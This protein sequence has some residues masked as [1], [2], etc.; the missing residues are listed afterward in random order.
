[1]DAKYDTFIID[2]PQIGN[3]TAPGGSGILAT[4]LDLTGL[5]VPRSPKQSGSVQGVV[6]SA[7]DAL[8]D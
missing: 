5:P 3:P 1:M 2:Q 8:R 7:V 6:R 4:R